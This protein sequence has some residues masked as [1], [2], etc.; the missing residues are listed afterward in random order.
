MTVLPS[1]LILDFGGVL[2]TDFWACLRAFEHREGLAPG[3]LVDLVT[4]DPA[5]HRLICDLEQGAI[6]QAEFEREA[7]AR[8]GVDPDG[9][10]ARMA[11]DLR[12][13]ERMLAAAAELRAGGAKLA[14]LSNS[15][16][17]DY[18]D[19]YAPWH[20]DDRADVVVISDRVGLRKPDPRIFALTVDRL[21]LPAGSCVFVD[22]IAAY[23]EPAAALG[24]RVVHHTDADHTIPA[25]RA[26]F[27]A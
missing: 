12:P 9:L 16:G 17:S 24:M 1:A 22:D 7:G 2:T 11:A 23:L 25:L 10:L 15:W 14:I 26:A 8:L 3:A 4:R 5:G 19:P 6:G 21:G 18:F 27:R 13:D 20:L